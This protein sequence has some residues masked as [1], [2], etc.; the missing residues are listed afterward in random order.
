M[1]VCLCGRFGWLCVCVLFVC[2][3]VFVRVVG[4]VPACLFVCVCDWLCV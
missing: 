4:C 2:V 1:C 3:W